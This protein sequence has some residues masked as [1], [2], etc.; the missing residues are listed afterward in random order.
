MR[1]WIQ[2]L[3]GRVLSRFPDLTPLERE[4]A[5][6]TARVNLSL[7]ITQSRISGTSNGQLTNFAKTIV[8]NC[9]HDIWRQNRRQRLRDNDL[10]VE[11]FR[12]RGVQP[13]EVARLKAQLE[14]ARHLIESWSPRERF[15]F[16]MKLQDVSASTIKADLER[17]FGE[18]IAVGSVD[19]L[20]S[21]LRGKVRQQCGDEVPHE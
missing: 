6:D 17:L 10:S 21:R 3:A 12:G 7:A 5:V 9:A 14:C 20:F 15:V 2:R 19:V 1:A 18:F 16:T 4:I 8:R 13:S 11:S